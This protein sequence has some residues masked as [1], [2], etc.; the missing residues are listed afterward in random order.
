MKLT[1]AK[2][3]WIAFAGAFLLAMAYFYTQVERFDVAFIDKSQDRRTVSL[4]DSSYTQTTNHF[5]PMPA[6]EDPV[7]G[8][9][10]KDQVNQWKAFV[11]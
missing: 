4:E 6:P 11:V 8:V 7:V 3:S 9:P 5:S 1:P 2:I 10:G